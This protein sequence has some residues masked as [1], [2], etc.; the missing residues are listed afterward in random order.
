MYYSNDYNRPID[1]LGG[2]DAPSH[3][4]QSLVQCIL[5][6]IDEY[7][8]VAMSASQVLLGVTPTILS[9]M[10][11]S[12]EE[13]AL[14]YVVGRS[15]FLAW[16]LALGSP[17]VYFNRAF[18]YR[19]PYEILRGHDEMLSVG[20]LGMVWSRV[21]VLVQYT[22][23]LCS[24]AN[25]LFQ[26][27]DLGIQTFCTVWPNNFMGPPMWIHIRVVLHILSLLLVR[28]RVRRN[29]GGVEPGE[30]MGVKDWF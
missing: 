17:S 26:T 7:I 3:N 2:G 5:N 16:L 28:L 15:P 8:K 9:I 22:L 25:I 19:N 4:I 12:V 1:Y 18:E 14:L 13:S 11:A 30:T 6:N 21:W 27:W 20:R 10:G 29:G 24:V 23:A